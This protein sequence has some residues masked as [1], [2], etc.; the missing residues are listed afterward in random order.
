MTGW[1]MGPEAWI[2]MGAWALVMV[3]V[4]WSLVR[5]PRRADRDDPNAILRARFAR[6]EIS[7]AEYRRA[8][9][10]LQADPP[11]PWHG[12]SHSPRGQETRHE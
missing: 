2:W 11:V 8:E 6:G 3:L 7:E 1:D 9:A 12:T 10:A 5:G 4:V